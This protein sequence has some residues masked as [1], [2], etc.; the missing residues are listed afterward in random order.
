MTCHFLFEGVCI[1][2]GCASDRRYCY[3]GEL[4]EREQRGHQYPALQMHS[5]FRLGWTHALALIFFKLIVLFLILLKIYC[6]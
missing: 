6:H 3:F 5:R 2:S 1:L 4:H